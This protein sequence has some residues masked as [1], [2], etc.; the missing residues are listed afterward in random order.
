MGRDPIGVDV[1]CR[2]LDGREFIDGTI[3]WDNDD[4]AWMLACRPLD[5]LAFGRKIGNPSLIHFIW[6]DSLLFKISPYVTIGRF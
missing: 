5:V 3:G 6:I 2:M 4:A 1:I